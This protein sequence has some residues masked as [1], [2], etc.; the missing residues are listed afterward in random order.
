VNL[1]GSKTKDRL[2][3]LF[4]ITRILDDDP[5]T[6]ATTLAQ[7]LEVSLRTVQR[8]LALLRE[9]EEVIS[10]GFGHQS[11]LTLSSA[12]STIRAEGQRC[13]LVTLDNDKEDAVRATAL[14][15]TQAEGRD[16]ERPR[17]ARRTR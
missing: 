14:P 10:E 17:E 12:T 5:D 9:I 15:I 2:L 13:R 3:R 11:S 7:L 6:H 16:S 1:Q 8:D 4:R